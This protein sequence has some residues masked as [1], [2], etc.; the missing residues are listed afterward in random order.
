[1]KRIFAA[2]FIFVCTQTAFSQFRPYINEIIKQISTNANVFFLAANR[3]TYGVSSY[4]TSK[5]DISIGTGIYFNRD[6]YEVPIDLSYGLSKR[7]EL[8][9]GVT[10]FM[11]SYNFLGEKVRGIGDSYIGIKY[12]FHESYY[13]DH[14][15]QAIIKI[16]TASRT[17]ELGT[18]KVDFF[19]GFAEGFT[20]SNFSYDIGFECNL[21]RRRDFPSL[22]ME[23][24]M[25]LREQLIIL[26]QKYDYRYEPEIALTVS[27]AYSFSDYFFLYTGYSFTRNTRLNFN[28]SSLLAG[29]G[30]STGKTLSF[31]IG[32]TY[33]IGENSGWNAGLGVNF[34]I[35]GKR[36]K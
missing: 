11:Q 13:F 34:L 36:K 26:K 21:L 29:I 18:G 2:V 14:V 10:A 6:I 8:S 9:A 16:P 33:G 22:N 23:M 1:M 30:V 12:R 20:V 17:S 4:I 24:P 32:S 5:G 7:T 27:P 28:T 19:F 25:I 3:P 35:Q 31:S 15:F